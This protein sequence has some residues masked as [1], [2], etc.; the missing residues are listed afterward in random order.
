MKLPLVGTMSARKR[1]RGLADLIWTSCE[2]FVEN[3]RAHLIH[4]PAYV[5]R[6]NLHQK[7]HLAVGYLCGN[8]ATGSHKFTFLASPPEGRL[9]CVRC[10]QAAIANGLPSSDE[11]AGRHVCK[12]EIRA[13][14]V[15]H[16]NQEE[17]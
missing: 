12:G 14:N 3:S 2:P 7:P 16:E 11:L 13:V 9:V 4:R 15:C 17:S 10:E 8:G 6:Y 1:A 5:V